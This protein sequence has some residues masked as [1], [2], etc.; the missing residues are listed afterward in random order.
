[1]TAAPASAPM[2][3]D[4]VADVVCPW[5]YVGWARLKGALA[6]RPDIDPLIRWRPYQ[7]NPELPEEGVGRKALMAAKF[8]SDPERL[9][10]VQQALMQQAA[11]AGI[12]LKPDLIEKSPNTSA[13]HRLIVWADQEGRGPELAEAV[14][15]AYWTELKDIGDPAVLTD[16]GAAHGMDREVLERRFAEGAGK[17]FVR[18]ACD[19]AAR[20]GV[21]GVPFM[22][23]GDRVAV[24]G[25]HPPEQLVQAIDK[26]RELAA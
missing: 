7:L 1:M 9:A 2:P 26:A 18:Q 23:F 21:Q 15:R 12:E 14:M 13:A 17:D 10:Q 16:I 25:A 5:C 20:A 24:S 3:I 6:L 8:G 4:Y 22:I 19:S 11:E